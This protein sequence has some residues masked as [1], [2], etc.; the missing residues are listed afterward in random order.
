MLSRKTRGLQRFDVIRIHKSVYYNL[1][2]DIRIPAIR[3]PDVRRP[4]IRN[5][6][7]RYLPRI[8]NS[9]MQHLAAKCHSSVIYT[10]SWKC[11]ELLRWV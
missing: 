6:H 10:N 11:L 4:D 8:H 3:I 1:E 9:V 5:I 7:P 2:P